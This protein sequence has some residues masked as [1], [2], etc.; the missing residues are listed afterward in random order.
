MIHMVLGTPTLDFYL[1]SKNYPNVVRF[2]CINNNVPD[3]CARFEFR[4]STGDLIAQRGTD[5]GQSYLTYNITEDSVIRCI[6]GEE[7]SNESMFA[8][9]VTMSYVLVIFI[10][11]GA[12]I[13]GN[14]SN[15]AAT[16]IGND[17]GLIYNSRFSGVKL[18]IGNL[19]S[20]IYILLHVPVNCTCGKTD[21]VIIGIAA[22]NI[23]S[24]IA[25]SYS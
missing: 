17:C 8:G 18:G 25:S 16:Q 23:N 4:N 10:A 22:F 3:P 12:S 6:I 20:M 24:Q 2:E 7:Q 14:V 11:P 19:H 9:K 21:W 5:A 15:L 1:R 13:S